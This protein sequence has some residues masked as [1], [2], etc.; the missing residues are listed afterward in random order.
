MDIFNHKTTIP[1]HEWCEP[2]KSLATY[3]T[4]GGLGGICH[5][6]SHSSLSLLHA[7]AQFNTQLKA[8]DIHVEDN[9]IPDILSRL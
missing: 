3:A 7:S 8:I 4:L 2:N 9:R 5:K 6:E 1:D